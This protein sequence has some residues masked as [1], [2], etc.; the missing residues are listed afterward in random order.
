M[1]E[2]DRDFPNPYVRS[3]PNKGRIKDP[4][5]AQEFYNLV[6]FQRSNDK[7][8]P[9]QKVTYFHLH[10][11][12][13]LAIR[14][15]AKTV[16]EEQRAQRD[17]LTQLYKQKAFEVSLNDKL[18]EVKK[19]KTQTLGVVR[20]DLD[21]FSWV[22]DV[23]G[24]HHLGDVYLSAAGR[25]LNNAIKMGK[26]QAFRVGG[27]E[28]A[29]IVN[30]PSTFDQLNK[31]V[32][33]YHSVLNGNIL[34]ATLKLLI[35]TKNEVEDSDG[36]IE[37]EGTVCLKEMIQ[38]MKDLKENK[39]NEK[40]IGLKDHFKDH[41]RGTPERKN[42]F[43]AAL[44][45]IDFS[46]YREYIDDQNTYQDIKNDLKKVTKRVQIENDIVELISKLFPNLTV[47]TAGVFINH[48]NIRGF[49]AVNDHL[50]EHIKSIKSVGGG[51][52]ITKSLPVNTGKQK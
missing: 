43:I 11:D 13:K 21:Y 31:A 30:D 49:K 26:D 25:M 44:E 3:G 32:G 16:R 33:R 7:V 24:A 18:A 40:G 14:Q 8:P 46:K 17:E 2:A 42:D 23:L 15:A 20:M 45:R 37:S 47:S 10:G 36:R 28:L 35:S 38:G 27:D 4:E 22:N 6:E 50:D 34:P 1:P 29:I 51:D 39:Q 5:V 41:A 52:H 12:D 9:N 19:G 48:E